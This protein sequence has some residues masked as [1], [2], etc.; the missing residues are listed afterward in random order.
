MA[1][2]E[3]D[4]LNALDAL[5]CPRLPFLPMEGAMKRHA[6]TIEPARIIGVLGEDG[7][8]YCSWSCADAG[9]QGRGRPVDDDQYGALTNRRRRDDALCPACGGAYGVSWSDDEEP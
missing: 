7:V 1:A 8:L 9:G 2:V 4:L 5:A 3:S 6:Q